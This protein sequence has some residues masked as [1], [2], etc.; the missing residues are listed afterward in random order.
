MHLIAKAVGI[1]HTKFNY[2]NRCAIDL[3]LYKIF[4]IMR[5]MF[6]GHSVILHVT[7]VQQ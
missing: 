2:Y 3:Q 4:K 6:F 5:V 1:S 7:V